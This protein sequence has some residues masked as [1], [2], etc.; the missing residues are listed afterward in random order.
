MTTGPG[1][2]YGAPGHG[3]GTPVP[4]AATATPPAPAAP[5]RRVPA[6]ALWAL[7]AALLLHA[8][9]A[10]LQPILIGGYLDGAYDLVGIHGLNGS[11]L[12]LLCLLSGLA[13]LAYWLTGGRAW[14]TPVL[15]ILWFAEGFQL[16][17]GYA[18]VLSLHI[19]LG[20]A[21]VALAVAVAGWAW[22]PRA[23]V[24]RQGW[25]R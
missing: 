10:V 6:G 18:R 1:V 23:R 17:M 24:P 3:G 15:A 5:A 8:V 13:A 19:P 22:T 9:D 14:L 21:I 11:L 16:G 7:R 2:G 25:W 20:V 4:A 12:L